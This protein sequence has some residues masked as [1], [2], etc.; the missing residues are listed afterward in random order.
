MAALGGII[1]IVALLGFAL[2]YGILILFCLTLKNTIEAADAHN[3]TIE[4]GKV[5]LMLIP[6]FNFIYP[7]ILFPKI[8]S[9]IKNQLEENNEAEA[10][11]YALMLGRAYPALYLIQMVI[12]NEAISGLLSLAGLVFFIIFWVKMGSYKIKMIATKSQNGT[13]HTV[14]NDKPDLLD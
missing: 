10:G 3:R 1:I 9:T 12:P 11:D 2:A 13:K 7:F 6:L 5:W 14:V 8:S 4:P